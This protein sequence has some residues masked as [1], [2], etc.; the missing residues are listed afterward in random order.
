MSGVECSAIESKRFAPASPRRMSGRGIIDPLQVDYFLRLSDEFEVA[1]AYRSR[2]DQR[3]L[4]RSAAL[5]AVP[6]TG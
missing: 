3:L 4:D 6:T 1:E 2:T 5:K